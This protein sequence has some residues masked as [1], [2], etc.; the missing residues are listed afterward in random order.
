MRYREYKQKCNAFFMQLVGR[1]CFEGNTSPEDAVIKRLVQYV[2]HT[3][4]GV[5][6]EVG[7]ALA[8]L[9][10]IA[11]TAEVRLFLLQ[12]MLKARYVLLVAW[13]HRGQTTT[14]VLGLIHPFIC[15]SH[16]F[17]CRP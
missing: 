9:D 4:M 5:S 6:E 1:L 8:T 15:P 17:C 16:I 7:P 10:A 13:A 14:I 11:P 3:P 12:F 2:T